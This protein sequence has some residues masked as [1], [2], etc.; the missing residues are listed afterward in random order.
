MA[1]KPGRSGGP[2]RGQG[3]KLKRITIERG[4]AVS[5]SRVSN[6][7]ETVTPA[8]DGEVIRLGGQDGHD[9]SFV[10]VTADET[11]TIFIG[12]MSVATPP[13]RP[14]TNTKSLSENLA[15]MK[16]L[17]QCCVVLVDNRYVCLVHSEPADNNQH[18][19]KA[20]LEKTQ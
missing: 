7:G 11:L 6:D 2:G 12:A 3:K 13:D 9:R 14:L 5:I 17:G 10:I 15:A 20:R 16:K 19:P 1:G 18:C 8:V 4:L